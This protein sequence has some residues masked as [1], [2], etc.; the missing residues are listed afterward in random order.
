MRVVP[1]FSKRWRKIAI[2]L[3]A[4]VSLGAATA[5]WAY[6]TT[7]GSGSGS[8]TVGTLDAP[9]GVGTVYSAGTTVQVN[10]TG[11]SHPG[12]GTF[13]YYVRRFVGSTPS[14][15]CNTSP[16]VLTTNVTCS[17]TGLSSGTYTYEVTAVFNSWTATSDA[18]APVTVV[19]D[20]TPPNAP[21]IVSPRTSGANSGTFSN[22]VFNASTWGSGCTSPATICGTA[23]DNVGGSGVNK[24]QLQIVG[25]SGANNAKYWNGTAFVSGTPAFFDA[26]GTTTWSYELDLPSDGNYTITA[27]TT[28]NVNLQSTLTTVAVTIDTVAPG[29]GA[30]AVAAAATSGSSPTFVDNEPVSL[31]DA[32]T[33]T[34]GSGV[35]SIAYF[36]CTGATGACTSA[37]PWTSIGSTTT[38]AGNW[39][40]TWVTPLPADGAYRLV[41]VAT[42]NAGNVST[43][44]T[45][46]QVSVDTTPP[47]V[48]R[49]IVN[50]HA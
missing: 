43:S 8:A 32:P 1:S 6:F 25:T 5:V 4:L 20:T 12:T 24:T 14:P 2:V 9:T 11:V 34:G 37:T 42:D 35:K 39:P 46:T 41:A 29:A 44:S 23:S 48:S 49:P 28:D 30:P 38:A 45:A 40:V 50:G 21:V 31:T 13:G 17:D 10:W 7:S 33:D 3:L 19:A 16:T 22:G 26:S 27:R 15:A 18:S 36:V 47:T